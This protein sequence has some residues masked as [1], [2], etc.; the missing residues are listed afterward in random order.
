MQ[1]LKEMR[2]RPALQQIK[3]M[4]TIGIIIILTVLISLGM[5]YVQ[6]IAGSTAVTIATSTPV[7]SSTA[8]SIPNGW[9]IFTSPDYGFS[10]AYPKDYEAS[11]TFASFYHVSN[12]WRQDI[13]EDADRT[14]GT[15]ALSI[16]ADQKKNSPG[17]EQYYYDAELRI[18]VSSDPVQVK[19]CLISSDATASSTATINGI[20]YAVYELP[21]V[22]MSQYADVT[23]YRTVH[24]NACYA[25]ESII[26]GGGTGPNADM[27]R[28][29]DLLDQDTAALRFILD[30][31]SFIQ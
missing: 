25:I 14:A 8:E 4:K 27:I 11:S 30:T 1:R 5:H 3:A 7:Q 9:K 12:A 29:Q 2:L 24:N 28:A 31:F 10:I 19:D 16:I 20:K 21:Q 13:F 6:G 23:S 17:E 15:E 26:T 22:G 18:G